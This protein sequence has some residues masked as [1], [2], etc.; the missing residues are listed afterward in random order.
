MRATRS[1]LNPDPNFS[2]WPI[3]SVPHSDALTI[4]GSDEMGQ[5]PPSVRPVWVNLDHSADFLTG[6]YTIKKPT[7]GKP[8]RQLT[9]SVGFGPPLP[10]QPRLCHS[11]CWGTSGPG[12]RS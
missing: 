2:Y 7:N 3:A 11:H 5:V 1:L 4:T 12:L 9:A 10:D 8:L 6:S